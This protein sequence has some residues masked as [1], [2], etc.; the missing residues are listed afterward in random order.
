MLFNLVGNAIKFTFKG[1]I[2]VTLNY[3]F[4]DNYL[5]T[6]IEDTGI[7]IKDED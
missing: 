6:E 3:N 5:V 7:G 1:Y 4:I 2:K